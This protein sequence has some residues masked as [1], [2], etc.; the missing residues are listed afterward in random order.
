[1]G[2]LLA[3]LK[4]HAHLPLVF[5]YGGKAVKPGYQH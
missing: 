5:L 1:M 2:D 4:D 3:F